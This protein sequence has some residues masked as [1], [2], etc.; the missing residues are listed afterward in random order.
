[1]SSLGSYLDALGSQMPLSCRQNSVL[2]SYKT[3]VLISLLSARCHSQ[4]LE[5]ICISKLMMPETCG[6][7][8]VTQKWSMARELLRK[9]R[10]REEACV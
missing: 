2:G 4:Y 6:M 1:M 3:E 5:S 8:V 10:I 7:E 9:R